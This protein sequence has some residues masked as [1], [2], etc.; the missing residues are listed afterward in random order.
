MSPRCSA[1][2]IFKFKIA[3][4][5]LLTKIMCT[6]SKVA[7]S[8]LINLVNALLYSRLI[9][10]LNPGSRIVPRGN[11]AALVSGLTFC[12]SFLLL[13]IDG[14]NVMRSSRRRN[15]ATSTL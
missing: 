12:A 1:G 2:Y 7:A 14:T 8:A 4:M 13:R 3:T 9:I 5:A 6:H 15:T 10:A 11:T